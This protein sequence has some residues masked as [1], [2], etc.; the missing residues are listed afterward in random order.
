MCAT[1]ALETK[2]PVFAGSL[3]E[4]QEKY[5]RSASLAADRGFASAAALPLLVK[6]MPLGVL[7]FH[8]SA[9]VNFDDDYQALMISV[10]QHC[11]QALDRA[12]LYEQ[13]ERARSDAEAANKLKDEFVSTVSHELRTPLNAILGWAS[14]L[15]TGSV[16]AAVVPQAVEAIH[17]NASRQAKL[18]DDLL[19]F[20]RIAGGRTALDLEPIDAPAFFR[21]IVESVIPLAAS[22]Q[23]EIQLSAIPEATVLGD[24]RRL[25]QVF[26]N[27]LGNSLKFTPPGGHISVSARITGRNLEVRVADDGIG[28]APEF[29]PHVFD[30]FRQGDGT[31]TRNHPGLGLGLSI[32]KQL[33]ET[34][35][36]SIRAES[37]GTGQ[38]TAFIVT[39]PID[40]R[41]ADTPREAS[42]ERRGVEPTARRRPSAGG[43]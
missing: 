17:R 11:T 23:I 34:H 29:L 4:L 20:A 41:V 26:V 32:A 43:R 30:R 2:K 6:G 8:F 18:V 22:N 33:V 1:V 14:M 13:A 31:S 40:A 24:V 19:D 36:G 35:N 7:E 39:L 25:E 38:G 10:A 9:P 27:L 28:I 16:D 5:W 37:G 42:V 12:R 21:G 3:D 15:R